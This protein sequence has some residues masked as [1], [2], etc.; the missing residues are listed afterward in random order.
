M[1]TYMYTYIQ[2]HVGVPVYQRRFTA[3]AILETASMSVKD[4][5]TSRGW[6]PKRGSLTLV[7]V[8]PPWKPMV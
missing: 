3:L 4:L 7:N 8:E 6:D 5:G 1:L 2:L